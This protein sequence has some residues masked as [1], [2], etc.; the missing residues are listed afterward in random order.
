MVR[1]FG[2]RCLLFNLVCMLDRLVILYSRFM[3]LSTFITLYD[4]TCP[5]VDWYYFIS[6]FGVSWVSFSVGFKLG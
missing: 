4:V 5:G 1:L 2:L 6:L 3:C